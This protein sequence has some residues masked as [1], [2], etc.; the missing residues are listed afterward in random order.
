MTTG[1]GGH[2]MTALFVFTQP[3][4]TWRPAL[5]TVVSGGPIDVFA[6]VDGIV[7]TFRQHYQAGSCLETRR[8]VFGWQDGQLVQRSEEV[9]DRVQNDP[10]IACSWP[11]S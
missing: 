7:G 8:H 6:T 10:A 3:S 11:T 1:A 9:V 5:A 2:P 4:G